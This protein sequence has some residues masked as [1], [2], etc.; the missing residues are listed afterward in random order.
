M[1]PLEN[2][3]NQPTEIAS[4]NS[5]AYGSRSI[6]LSNTGTGLPGISEPGSIG[7][8]SPRPVLVL[9]SFTLLYALGYLCFAATQRM[10]IDELWTFYLASAPDFRT[11]W[12][13]IEDGMELN[14]PLSFFLAHIS[15]MAFGATDFAT[16]LPAIIGF[17]VMCMALFFFMRARVGTMCAYSAML[18]PF[19]TLATT[20]VAEA[21]AYSMVL[22]ASAAALLFWQKLENPARRW[23]ALPGLA[24]SCAALV[25]LHYY[26]LYVV[27]VIALAEAARQVQ[28]R[29][30]DIWFWIATAV[31]CAPLVYLIPIM[32]KIHAGARHFEM[33]PSSGD[34]LGVYGGLVAPASLAILIVIAL[35]TRADMK[36]GAAPAKESD[37]SG[38]RP[39]E[40]FAATLLT[41]M[42]L[43]AY[44]AAIMVTNAFMARYVLPVVL[45]PAILVPAFL[46]RV[47]RA[48][49]HLPVT[50]ACVLF[51]LFSW[52]QVRTI[53]AWTQGFLKQARTPVT[54]APASNSAKPQKEVPMV[55]DNDNQFLQITRYGSKSL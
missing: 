20:H 7:A 48:W 24:I 37:E 33:A 1:I 10:W 39:H 50:A 36:G 34:F 26:A 23:W 14:P 13:A 3:L 2:I 52:T 25:S 18:L 6:N 12:H 38:L 8:F 15:Q 43:A 35:G 17:W 11:I 44:A 31:G 47:S 16:R 32:K 42:P 5:P 41:L 27:I 55:I 45:G 51:A 49:P 40:W 9:S 28:K 21:R 30:L 54:A 46:K 19:F 4:P 29:S 22:G 53:M